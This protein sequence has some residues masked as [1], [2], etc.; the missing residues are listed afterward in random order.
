VAAPPQAQAHAAAP[1]PARAWLAKFTNDEQDP[2]I[3][4]RVHAKVK[5]LVTSQEEII[6]IAV[7]KKPVVNLTPDCVVLTNRRL[8]LYKPK[9]LGQ[10]DMQDFQWLNVFDCRVKEGMTGATL[11]FRIANGATLSVDY[12]P[13]SQ[14]RALYRFAQEMEER[15]IAQRR[16]MELENARAASGAMVMQ[17]PAMPAA[18]HA[19]PQDDPLA[20][21]Q[22]LKQLLDAGLILQAEYDAKKAEILKRM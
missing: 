5:E 21:L 13:K 11:S 2:A 14:A 22:K 3:V 19:A 16:Q 1:N 7:Q 18:T 20:T 6:Y 17:P 4:E 12:L 9:L 10:V 8:I 15:S